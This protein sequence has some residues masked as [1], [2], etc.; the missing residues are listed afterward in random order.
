MEKHFSPYIDESKKVIEFHIRNV[1]AK[2]VSLSGS[3]NNWAQDVLLMQP[4][5]DGE[6]KI[7][8]PLLPKGNYK[9]KFFI[10][11]K[12]WVEDVE[13]P[14]REPDGFNGWNSLLTV[15]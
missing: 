14:Y 5:K 15:Q 7:E 8:I 11:D 12:M 9:Y 1:C 3:F 10:D 2:Q 4:G 6:W 13:N